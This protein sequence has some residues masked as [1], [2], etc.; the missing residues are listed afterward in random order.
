MKN[1][2]SFKKHS[3]KT[4]TF[5]TPFLIGSLFMIPD[6]YATP[7]NLSTDLGIASTQQTL[8]TITGV[9][10]D[11]SYNPIIGASVYL[12]DSSKGTITDIDGKFSLSVPNNAT[13]IV[14]YIGYTKQEIA[15]QNQTKLSITLKEDTK[16]LDDVV[17]TALG[18]KREKKALGYAMQEIKTNDF[19][20]NRSSN[21]SN[22]LQ[23]KVAGV[24]ISQ[25]G[26]GLGGD[27]R[28]ILRGLN[29]LSGNNSPLWVVDGLPILNDGLSNV[30]FSYS[31]GAADINPDDIESV[32]VLKGANAAALYG[33]RAQSGA[34]IITTKKGKAGKIKFDYNGYISFSK[35]YDSYEYQDV[36]GQGTKGIYSLTAAG[37]WGPKM[38][39]QS[40]PN[41]RK[42]FYG[43]D[44]YRS[45]AMLP[46]KN[47]I[48]KFFRTALNY[49]NSISASGGNE[50]IN[51][52]FSFTDSRNEGII[53]NESV[54]KQNYNLNVE[55]KNKYLTIGGKV[56]YFR[57]KNKNRP[58]TYNGVW[59]NLIIMPRN[60][61]L[62][63]LQNPVGLNGNVESW[64]GDNNV[65]LNPYSFVMDGNGNKLERDRFQG[66][67]SVT[68]NI[69]SF[70]K[71]TGRIGLDRIADN[72]ENYRTYSNPAED[73]KDLI[74]I[75]NF[76]REELNADLMLNL[77]KTFKDFSL[78]ANFGGRIHKEIALCR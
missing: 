74:T 19:Q 52:R 20:E 59:Q 43:N 62:Q 9:V 49:T 61:R 54:N 72:V 21:V 17:V 38:E 46:E 18:I 47:I 6:S 65:A 70:L 40:I 78:T 35:A 56:S 44:K 15:L 64:L 5:F 30:Q 53:P 60:I 27:T 3:V 42:E 57:E 76:T 31:S 68:G 63:D 8:K 28:V 51:A 10:T 7:F 22:L 50:F 58:N 24:Q 73:V 36:Y 69:C 23:G 66:L 13:L 25:S 14:S 41:W 75:D 67:L 71:V 34:I 2:S 16:L 37:S 1:R 55:I 77:N 32:S 29:S 4:R 12:K 11:A 39:G 26:S 48:N 45:Y 33:S